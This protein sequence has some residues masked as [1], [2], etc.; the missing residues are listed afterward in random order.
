LLEAIRFRFV[1]FTPE[2]P[3]E[4]SGYTWLSISR[5]AKR[6]F[7]VGALFGTKD[8]K[9]A[10]KNRKASAQADIRRLMEQWAEAIR[11]KDVDGI[12]SHYASDIVVFDLAPPLQ[13][14]G[15]NAYR[16]NWQAWFHT[17]QGPIGYEIRDRSIVASNDIAF[18][19]GFNR[20]TGTRTDGE[21]TDVWVRAT[22]C[23]RKVDGMWKIVHEHQSV[24]FYMD[25]SYRAALDLNP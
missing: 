22:V 19:H 17:F 7:N 11:A 2:Y 12:M 13:Y 9:M 8:R 5:F 23:C 16:E 4:F 24:P 21:K 15:A 18:C 6:L 25:G 3:A 10:K 1:R 20:I 14:K